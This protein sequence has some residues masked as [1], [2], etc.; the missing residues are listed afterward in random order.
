MKQLA[1]RRFRLRRLR[2]V[3]GVSGEGVVVEG[4]QFSDGRVAC[5]WLTDLPRSTVVWDS[6][7][8]AVVV[9]GHDGNTV[10]EWVD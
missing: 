2:D 7:T 1:F 9:H 6:V 8:E 3:S 5:R 10:L 4:V